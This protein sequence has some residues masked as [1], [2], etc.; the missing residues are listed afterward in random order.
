MSRESGLLVAASVGKANTSL[1]RKTTAPVHS[2]NSPTE[3]FLSL[4]KTYGNRAVQSIVERLTS[5][6]EQH[7]QTLNEPK[8]DLDHSKNPGSAFRPQIIQTRLKIG[9]PNDKYE[10][11]ADQVAGYSE[12]PRRS[13]KSKSNQFEASSASGYSAPVRGM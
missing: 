9:K 1:S 10:Q 5:Y 4:Q 2:V 7:N 13:I 12:P 11:E 3:R 8:P 6:G